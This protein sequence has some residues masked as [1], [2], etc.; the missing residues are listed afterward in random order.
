M[1]VELE[2][3][4]QNLYRIL[5]GG[6]KT[7][8]E[9]TENLL[10]AVKQAYA[11]TND[12]KTFDALCL[13]ILL[14]VLQVQGPIDESCKN[15]LIPRLMQ[16]L[17]KKY[18]RVRVDEILQ[19]VC[20]HT[21]SSRAPEQIQP[22]PAPAPAQ[23]EPTPPE[24]A[25]SVQPDE[26]YEFP[27]LVDQSTEAKEK[28]RLFECVV[29]MDRH[30]QIVFGN[31]G[32]CNVCNDCYLTMLGNVKVCPMC[33]VPIG[34]S[35]RTIDENQLN[36]LYEQHMLNVKVVSLE[37]RT[38][39]HPDGQQIIL[40]TRL[41]QTRAGPSHLDLQELLRQLSSSE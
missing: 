4:V 31:C 18:R 34:D 7:V 11:D 39:R 8:Q 9:R 6:N 20:N 12:T 2:L 15:V 19:G 3:I 33:R 37:F 40:N 27:L 21:G 30:R 13:D 10:L 38:V 16:A 25:E 29:C 36:Y 5:N 41:C 24:P 35:A 28:Q 17:L 23:T 22:Q 26:E 1:N 14:R 32:H